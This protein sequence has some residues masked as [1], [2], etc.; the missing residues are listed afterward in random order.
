MNNLFKKLFGSSKKEIKNFVIDN[1]EMKL[2]TYLGKEN[3][4]L[5]EL[6]KGLSQ[7]NFSKIRIFNTLENKEI[8]E[9]YEI[10]FYGS[11]VSSNMI[12]DIFDEKTCTTK[13]CLIVAK[14]IQTGK[15]ILLYDQAK[16]GY[17]PVFCDEFHSE[18]IK[19]RPLV[20][21][22][23]PNSKI[24]IDFGYSIDFEEEKEDFE[25]DEAD[26]IETINGEKIAFEEVKK[27]CFDYIKITAVDEA[28]N[29]RVICE[30]ELA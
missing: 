11:V 7:D 17:N 3:V 28:D 9:L 14:C 24:E 30:L 2:P 29:K 10:Y 27:N 23:I 6:E 16:Y 25:F 12:C 21:L 8:N 18:D 13:P 15:E 22:E 20:K 5:L 1:K 19:N 26:M 4:Q